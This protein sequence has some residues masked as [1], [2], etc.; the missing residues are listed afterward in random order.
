MQ[1]LKQQS[2]LFWGY[3]HWRYMLQWAFVLNVWVN[4]FLPPQPRPL[5]MTALCCFWPQS[6]T[7]IWQTVLADLCC[8]GPR[9]SCSRQR[10]R[11]QG[12][13]GWTN[14]RT[15]TDTLRDWYT[16]DEG[17]MSYPIISSSK[18]TTC[19]VHNRPSTSQRPKNP[20]YSTTLQET[21]CTV[22]WYKLQS[23]G[24]DWTGIKPN[25]DHRHLHATATDC[26]SRGEVAQL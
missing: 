25:M 5:P 9:S 19:I 12:L 18:P 10:L 11:G 20:Q 14:S 2:L 26:P 1:G 6:H 24:H 22:C 16:E 7:W 23:Y 13:D 15:G 8:R 21:H 17:W 4:R 3:L